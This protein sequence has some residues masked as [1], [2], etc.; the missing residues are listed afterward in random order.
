[1]G[2][3]ILLILTERMCK[4]KEISAYLKS[5]SEPSFKLEKLPVKFS[6][7]SFFINEFKAMEILLEKPLKDYRCVVMGCFFDPCV[8]FLRM[9]RYR[10]VGCGEASMMLASLLER[11]FGVISIFR[12]AVS[13]VKLMVKRLGLMDRFVGIS[14]VSEREESLIEGGRKLVEEGA[15]S[16]IIAHLTSVKLL[17]VLSNRFKGISIVEPLKAGLVLANAM[18]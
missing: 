13:R 7:N 9:R 10:V 17:K 8:E 5:I 15:D 14:I 11:D 2:D 3:D 6:E 16:L 18:F 4:S 12:E 1:M